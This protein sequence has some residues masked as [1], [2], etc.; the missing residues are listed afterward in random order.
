[1]DTTTWAE[2]IAAVIDLEGAELAHRPGVKPP[3]A[4]PDERILQ[5][6]EHAGLRGCVGYPVLAVAVLPERDRCMLQL[7]DDDTSPGAVALDKHLRAVPL[8]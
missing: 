6:L 8:L 7:G 4:A 1:M 2:W 3:D 5:R